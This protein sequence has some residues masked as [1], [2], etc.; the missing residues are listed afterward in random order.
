MTN[1]ALLPFAQMSEVDQVALSELYRRGTPANTLRACAV[2]RLH[3]ATPRLV[4]RGSMVH[5]S[6]KL[7]ASKVLATVT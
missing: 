5:Q 3:S 7:G 6:G 4:L 1:L 2:T